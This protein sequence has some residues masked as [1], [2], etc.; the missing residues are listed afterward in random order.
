MIWGVLFDQ[1]PLQIL[2]GSNSL[3][4]V[5]V[6]ERRNN[7]CPCYVVLWESIDSVNLCKVHKVG[8]FNFLEP[9]V[10]VEAAVVEL[11]E[12]AHAISS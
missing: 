6:I 4:F 5:D 12:E 9:K 10:G 2:L 8:D 11:A 7:L 3:V 1:N